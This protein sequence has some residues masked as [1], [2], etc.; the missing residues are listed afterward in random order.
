MRKRIKGKR[1]PPVNVWRPTHPTTEEGRAHL[2]ELLAAIV[3]GHGVKGPNK[4]S[5]WRAEDIGWENPSNQSRKTG[6]FK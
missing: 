2:R 1:S 5:Y 4:T 3:N 6:R